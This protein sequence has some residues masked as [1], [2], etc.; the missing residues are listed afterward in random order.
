V[1]ASELAE[2]FVRTLLVAE[3]ATLEPMVERVLV[4]A[5]ERR[6][7]ADHLGEPR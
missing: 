4:T 7:R 1:V 6:G 2:T 3:L 5:V